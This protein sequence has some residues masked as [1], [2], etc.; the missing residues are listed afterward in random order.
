M[1]N[2]C[3]AWAGSAEQPIKKVLL[4]S[5]CS[6]KLLISVLLMP[7]V[8]ESGWTVLTD[9][10]YFSVFKAHFRCRKK[11]INEITPILGRFSSKCVCRSYLAKDWKGHHYSVAALASLRWRREARRSSLVGNQKCAFVL[12]IQLTAIFHL[13]RQSTDQAWCRPILKPREVNV[14]YQTIEWRI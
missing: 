8:L 14:A 7:N 6:P 12:S 3:S 11:L 4:S 13:Q 5:C 9:N 1:R 10:V 2:F